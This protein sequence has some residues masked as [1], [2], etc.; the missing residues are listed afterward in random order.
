MKF[1]AA[2][3]F[4][5][6]RAS[7]PL[8]I[9]AASPF[10]SRFRPTVAVP[11]RD[12]PRRRR[13]EE[14]A[15]PRADPGRPPPR[16]LPAEATPRGLAGPPGGRPGGLTASHPGRRPGPRPRHRRQGIDSM[17]PATCPRP[18]RL[19]WAPAFSSTT[20]GHRASPACSRHFAALRWSQVEGAIAMGLVDIG[21]SLEQRSRLAHKGR[22]LYG[23]FCGTNGRGAARELRPLPHLAG[24]S[25][26]RP[27]PARVPRRPDRGPAWRGPGRSAGDDRGACRPHPAAPASGRGRTAGPVAIGLHPQ[28]QEAST[29]GGRLE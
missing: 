3:R 27:R 7:R 25:R 26:G 15:S 6:T 10:P 17:S 8:S 14:R 21:L 29:I 28:G 19:S 16:R 20:V 13:L 22:L 18:K 24:R 23:K 2:P 1:L 9:L 4:R 12:R 11:I 5:P